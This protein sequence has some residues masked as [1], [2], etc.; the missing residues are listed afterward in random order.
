M[1]NMFKM[2]APFQKVDSE[3]RKVYGYATTDAVDSQGE[4]IDLAASFEAVDEYK[5]WATIKEMHRPETAAGI[6]V[7]I[8]KHEG[9][10][11]YVG[12]EIVDDQAW[13][14]TEKGVY[15]GFSIGGRVLERKGNHI[16]K[17]QLYEISLV[18]RPANPDAL[19]VVTKRD[20]NASATEALGGSAVENKPEDKADSGNIVVKS[21]SSEAPPDAKGAEVAKSEVV[22]EDKPEMVSISKD[23][24]QKMQARIDELE[25][26]KK[27]Q[28]TVEQL[29]EK[30]VERLEPKIK[31]VYE[32][33]APLTP[34]Q[35]KE[36]VRKQLKS[37]DMGSL[38]AQ[39]LRLAPKKGD[40]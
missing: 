40:D 7:S 39:M 20:V 34:E 37:M 12:A 15:K 38:T 31:K 19:F 25:K 3:N 8:E 29:L 6:A 30:M 4:V 35:H 9:V 5:K 13:K 23:E 24:L 11:V 21:A 2:Y 22:K 17:Y 1:D 32:E 16:T 18:D 14:K 28:A 33:Q 10:G 26:A 27:E 36:E